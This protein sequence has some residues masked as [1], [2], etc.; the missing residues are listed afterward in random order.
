[1]TATRAE[2]EDVGVTFWTR[3]GAA[4]PQP[5]QP[6]ASP[7]GTERGAAASEPRRAPRREAD[8]PRGLDMPRGV[9]RMSHGAR[10]AWC[11]ASRRLA[12]PAARGK[13]PGPVSRGRPLPPSVP[14]RR[15]LSHIST[16]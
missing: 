12:R 13:A 6:P 2:A 4:E 1:M 8:V 10:R 15:A 16:R 11:R 7:A 5:P 3:D 14:I 9:R